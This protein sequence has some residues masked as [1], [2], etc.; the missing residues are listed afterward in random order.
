MLRRSLLSVMSWAVLLTF[1]VESVDAHEGH[2]PAPT[3]QPP[4]S[5]S[6]SQAS[7][8]PPPPSLP[9]DSAPSQTAAPAVFPRYRGQV[10][11]TWRHLWEIIYEPQGIRIFLYDTTGAPLSTRGIVGD[12][13]LEVGGNPRQWRFPAEYVP[14]TDSRGFAEQLFVRADLSRVR[15]GDMSV[16]FDF[17]RLPHP[18]E[19]NVRFA[20]TFA[21]TPAGPSVQIGRLEEADRAAIANQRLCPVTNS[22]FTHGEPIK[23]LVDGKPLFVCCEDCI[24]EVKQDPL[25]FAG[26]AAKIIPTIP[27]ESLPIPPAASAT[28]S[29]DP[30]GVAGGNRVSVVAVTIVDRD[31]MARQGVCPMTG[32]PLDLQGGPLRVTTNGQ[33]VYVC[34]A[35]CVPQAEL[36]LNRAPTREI[37]KRAACK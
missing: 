28:I 9:T 12:V 25:K 3:A 27:P 4:A 2:G 11:S 22:E 15:D 37:T 30:D 24:E 33:Y 16:I 32:R 8:T 14:P 5:Q 26:A 21:L 17:Q 13:V 7:L 23:L 1:T 34:C 19:P 31:G 18:E 36:L 20:Q 6:V 29:H 35:A 10:K